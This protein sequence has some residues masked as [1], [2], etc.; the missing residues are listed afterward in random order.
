MAN[1]IETLDEL[2]EAIENV[3]VDILMHLLMERSKDEDLRAFD[4]VV[5]GAYRLRLSEY[6]EQHQQELGVVFHQFLEQFPNE[7]ISGFGG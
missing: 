3:R 2:A 1:I 7:D 6:S 5:L 4:E